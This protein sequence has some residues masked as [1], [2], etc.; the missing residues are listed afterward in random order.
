MIISDY[1]T[2][3]TDDHTRSKSEGLLFRL[4][5]LRLAATAP[6]RRAEEIFEK[7]IIEKS[8]SL[9]LT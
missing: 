8:A 6:A 9:L 4:L 3:R 7:R 5:L 2:V 1:I